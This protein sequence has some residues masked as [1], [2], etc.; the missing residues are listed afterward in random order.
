MTARKQLG[1][2]LLAAALALPSL[3]GLLPMPMRA[4]ASQPVAATQDATAKLLAD[5]S[6]ICTPYGLRSLAEHN[7]P[8]QPAG[9]IAHDICV[10]C[11]LAANASLGVLHVEAHCA[12]PG[13]ASETLA[14]IES[15]NP[16]RLA[17]NLPPPGRGPPN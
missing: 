7:A 4:Q 9:K 16:L 10:L 3:I 14:A 15:G 17:F 8:A 2:W 11:G 1:I 6:I 5:L 12:A 13:I